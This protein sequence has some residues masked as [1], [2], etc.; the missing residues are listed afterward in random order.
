MSSNTE[1]L[2]SNKPTQEE[3]DEAKKWVEE[4]MNDTG[5]LPKSNAL[6]EATIEALN[7]LNSP[8]TDKLTRQKL[9]DKFGKDPIYLENLS[10]HN[11]LFSFDH[12]GQIIQGIIN[13]SIF[14]WEFKS[15]DSTFL[16]YIPSGIL[17]RKSTFYGR[18]KERE[19]FINSF[20]K[21]LDEFA[22]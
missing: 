21:V 6:T 22:V 9:I 4:H 10:F 19:E 14:N 12:N 5:R 8:N 13:G 11:L 18:D 17:A 2:E 3:I 1:N 15:A 7:N 16:K 20:Y